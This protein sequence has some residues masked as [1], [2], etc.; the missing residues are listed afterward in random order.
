MTTTGAR[1]NATGAP[2]YSETL[3]CASE[4]ARRARMLTQT[5]MHSWG[6]ASLAE[7]GKLIVS[8][9]VS[10]VIVHT[11]CHLTRVAITRVG[12][13]T[14]RIAVADTSPLAPAIST[15]E[16]DSGSGRGLFLVDALSDRWGYDLHPASK[17]VWA[18][19]RVRADGSGR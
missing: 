5:A 11:R 12:D 1:P 10:N 9:L 16:D 6:L 7:D 8:E 2:G 17:V 3:P 15:S 18:E 4:S 13:D 19:L 14:V